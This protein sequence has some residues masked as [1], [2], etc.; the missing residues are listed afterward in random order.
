MDQYLLYSNI[1]LWVVQI[2][3][4][5]SIFL[6]YRQFGQVYLGTAD[7]I[8]RDGIP[9]GDYL[10][11]FEGLSYFNNELYTEKRLK[12]LNKPT[13]MAFV[14]PNCGSC[15]DL[16][17][18]WNKAYEKYKN[19]FNFVIM[20]VGDDEK[21]EVFLKN[22]P[23]KGHLILDVRDKFLRDFRVRVTPFAFAINSKQVVTG[24]G[25]CNDMKH[26]EELI[27]SVEV[28]KKTIEGVILNA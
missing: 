22:R 28:N 7:G 13:L 6:I 23:L 12:D 15:K 18:E 3:V 1:L 5:L 4:L 9:I 26:I 20:G 2:V 16:I 8:S 27:S 14:S 19:Q 25:L 11:R 24:K 17:P 21:F 10:P